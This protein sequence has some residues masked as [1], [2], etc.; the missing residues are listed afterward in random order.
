[1]SQNSAD[2][3]A[4]A[5]PPASGVPAR[6]PS[7]AL[8]R[9]DRYIIPSLLLGIGISIAVFSERPVALMLSAVLCGFGLMAMLQVASSE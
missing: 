5:L 7:R 4:Q 2:Q 1:M 9:R 6:S 3:S 8:V